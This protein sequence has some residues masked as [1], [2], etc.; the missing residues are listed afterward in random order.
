MN[1]ELL[2]KLV[3]TP[4]VSGREELVR[5]LVIEELTPLTDTIDT[6]V[7]G[8]VIAF[9]KGSAK[10]P[11][12]KI[13][14]AAH[15]D[16]IGFYVTY[17]DDKGFIRFHPA[18]GFDPTTLKAQRVT[19]HGKKDITGVIGA[20]PIHVLTEEEKKKRP[21]LRDYFIDLGMNKEEVEEIVSLGDT[22][23]LQRD[24]DVMG[25]CLT[26]RSFDDRVGVFVMIEALRKLKKSPADLY[27][28]GTTQ[29]E[30]GLRGAMAAASGILPDIGI[31]L[32]GTLAND[33]PGVAPQD[34]VSTLG[35]GTAISF[36]N[37]AAISN[38]KLFDR[39]VELAEK[40]KIKYQKDLLP[41]G[42]TDAGAIQ[43]APGGSA[44]LTLSVPA[45]YMHTT[46]ETV[47]TEDVQDT[48]DLLTAYL[49][50]PG[51]MDYRL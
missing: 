45:R 19:V 3:E 31:A 33:F 4:G 24:M 34:E 10:A 16:Q 30:V 44:V 1:L 36:M 25:K 28:V 42:G 32:D 2:R 22:I 11:R 49:A 47:H 51:K 20:K 37:G 43:R 40:K 26:S 9:K 39:F 46:V 8:N 13:M 41:K 17:I 50:E 29:E 38:P 23:T 6:D 18:G 48:I 14:V 35:G 15:M 7:L 5:K 12:K 27:I 21:E